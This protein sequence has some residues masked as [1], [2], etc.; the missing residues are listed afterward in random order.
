VI[1]REQMGRYYEVMHKQK[2]P[3]DI[4]RALIF[5]GWP[6]GLSL[7]LIPEGHQAIAGV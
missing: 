2:G 3:S 1:N 5:L 4:E 6:M 7:G